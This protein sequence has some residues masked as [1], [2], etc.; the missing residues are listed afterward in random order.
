MGGPPTNPEAMLEQMENPMFLS[1]LNEAMN[2]PAVVDMMLQSPMVSAGP[3]STLLTLSC[4][5]LT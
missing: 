2:N 3:Y 5:G 4:F 1:Q